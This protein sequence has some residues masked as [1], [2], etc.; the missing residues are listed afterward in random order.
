M[1]TDEFF[2]NAAHFWLGYES[3]AEERIR[4]SLDMAAYCEGKGWHDLAISY[5][6][7]GLHTAQDRY[8]HEKQHAGWFA[9]RPLGPDPDEALKHLSE[10]LEAY[11]TTKEYLSDYQKQLQEQK[12]KGEGSR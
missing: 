12:C 10:Y 11:K 2:N 1:D 9:H 4:Y 7:S 5:L 8:A 6:E 3:Q